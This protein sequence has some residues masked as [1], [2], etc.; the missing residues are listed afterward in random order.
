MDKV[1][2]LYKQPGETPLECILRYKEN[3]PQFENVPMTY[4]G[5]LDPLA[6]GVLL[7]LSGKEVHRK[8]EF[9]NL[10]KEYEVEVLFGFET[11]TYDV[12][13]FVKEH[14]TLFRQ[15]FFWA[16]KFFAKNFLRSHIN[17]CCN[18]MRPHLGSSASGLAKAR[19]C[20]LTSSPRP[21]GA[22]HLLDKIFVNSILS[23]KLLR[24]FNT[25]LSLPRPTKTSALNEFYS[26]DF[27]KAKAVKTLRDF[28]GKNIF[29]YPQYSSKPV[30]GKP[31]F[32]LARSG[33]LGDVEMP[34]REVE[35]Y[36]LEILNWREINSKDLLKDIENK[37]SNV[38]G[39]FRQEVIVSKWREILINTDCNFSIVK[40]KAEVSSGTYMRTLAHEWGKALGIPALAYHIVRTKVGEYYVSE[41]DKSL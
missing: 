18:F 10:K 15:K 28:I 22:V 9:L 2:N 31:L 7:V 11:D 36:N 3:N 17:C 34:K 27:N 20:F 12:L 5:R 41:S 40:I 39:D 26:A 33:E 13:G 38:V 32:S 1:L 16:R 8:E 29:E 24:C 4:A 21:T 30:N 19:Q 14:K 37:I 35:I 23:Q 25:Y 6:E